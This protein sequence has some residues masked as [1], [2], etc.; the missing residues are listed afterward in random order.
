M[1]YFINFFYLFFI[2]KIYLKLNITIFK[3]GPNTF[4]YIVY[5]LC[6]ILLNTSQISLHSYYN[7]FY[8]LFNENLYN[9]YAI[10]LYNDILLEEDFYRLKMDSFNPSGSGGNPPTEPSQGGGSPTPGPSGNNPVPIHTTDTSSNDNKTSEYNSDSEDSYNG[11][12]IE[13]LKKRIDKHEGDIQKYKESFQNLGDVIDIAIKF[14][15]GEKVSDEDYAKLNTVLNSMHNNDTS[16]PL[17]E[18]IINEMKDNIKKM[19]ISESK[20]NS[21]INEISKLEFIQVFKDQ[22]IVLTQEQLKEIEQCVENES[23]RNHLANLRAIARAIIAN[24]NFL[25]Q[26]E[27]PIIVPRL[28]AL[29]DKIK[30]IEVTEEA[31]ALHTSEDKD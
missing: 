11:S 2:N 6:L 4:L 28:T 21:K 30:E 10:Y 9:N 27:R 22:G 20:I 29:I 13:E 19:G 24:D 16:K 23:Q 1:S 3:L 5:I 18:A 14:E 17:T 26:K 15:K 7:L 25:E 31:K 12:D 8:I